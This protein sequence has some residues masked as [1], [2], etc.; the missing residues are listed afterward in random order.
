VAGRTVA[1]IPHTFP[2]VVTSEATCIVGALTVLRCCS[3]SLY[4]F[5]NIAPTGL[6][7]H[8][9]RHGVLHWL[10]GIADLVLL[11]LWQLFITLLPPL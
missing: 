1:R 4:C 10:C 9:I 5:N 2:V 8:S 3:A 11:L 6:L 7:C